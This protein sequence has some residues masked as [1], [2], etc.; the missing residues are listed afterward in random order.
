[1]VNDFYQDWNSARNF[2]NGLPIYANIDLTIERYLGRLP[3]DWPAGFWT[4]NAHPP[5]SVLLV[6]P[7]AWLEYQNA[8]LMWTIISFAAL[9]VALWLIVRHLDIQVSAWSVLPCVTML[10]L[11]YPFRSQVIH[12]Q[13]NLILLLLVTL[14]WVAARSGYSRWA[15]VALG[16]ATAIKLFPGLLFL[17][18]VLRREW[19][20]LAF[21]ATTLAAVTGLTA[22][23]FPAGTFHT[24]LV[25]V[26][27]SLSKWQSHASNISLIGFWSKLFDPVSAG[28]I[29]ILPL[30]RSH[31]LARLGGLLSCGLV[32][33]STI[34]VILGARTR[35]D[36][37][38][39]FG[40][41]VMATILVSPIAWDHY[42]L[43]LIVPLAIMWVHLERSGSVRWIWMLMVITLFPPP[44]L[45][46]KYLIPGTW[47]HV[48]ATPLYVLTAL[49][50]QF[51]TLLGLFTFQWVNAQSNVFH[52]P[53]STWHRRARL[54]CWMPDSIFAN[55]SSKSK[56]GE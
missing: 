34:P 39:A 13:F 27:P 11:C 53:F 30:W 35:S 3:Q 29:T 1:M 14:V 7:F 16:V 49:S 4:V 19:K 48:T 38:Q 51:Y 46:W 23:A 44:G 2:R 17:Y 37:D 45:L 43:L 10:L 25:E 52:R 28:P 24:Y 33:A 40:L 26:L 8:F 20:V 47:P 15:G 9:S 6:Y 18:F 31:L 36:L 32:L 55:S 21:G 56:P 5:A 41:L 22:V 12:G 54:R 50:F 42:L